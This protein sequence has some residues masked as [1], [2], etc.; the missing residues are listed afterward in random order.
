[1]K[2]TFVVPDYSRVA[3]GMRVIAEHARRLRRRGHEVVVVATPGGKP[4]MVR[5][6]FDSLR[7]RK[8]AKGFFEDGEM[9]LRLLDRFRPVT[10][11][12]VPDADVVVATWWRT[13]PGVAALSRKKGAKALF[14]QG[15]ELDPGQSDPAI[16]ATWRMPLRKI[17]VARWL[18]TL[19]ATRFD[20][21]AALLVPNGVD[22]SHFDAPARKR[23]ATP[24]AGLVY[25]K[26]PLKGVDVSLEAVRRAR[27]ELPA[28]RLVAFGVE[29]ED[30]KLPF[31]DGTVYHREPAQASLPG[32]YAS[33]DTWLW[34]SRQEG[35]GLPLLEAMACRTPV[36]A[37]DAGAAPEILE[38]TGGVVVPTGDPQA[39]ADALLRMLRLP[40][41]D[42][43]RLSESARDVASSWSWDRASALFEDALTRTR[44]E[45]PRG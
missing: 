18:R 21:R 42:W 4:S 25:W 40:E 39:M 20:D 8:P 13:A 36:V 19:A 11:A 29:P 3:G 9:E 26:L 33:C 5:R 45:A 17:V 12:D 32:I 27:R 14:I 28:L 31:P 43:G 35:F 10:D 38:R 41:A 30:R 44:E 6:I 34:G 24:T 16:D 22:A 7:G 15:Y 37:T 1:M 2:I 23:R